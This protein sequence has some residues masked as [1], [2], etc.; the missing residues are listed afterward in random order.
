MLILVTMGIASASD[1]LTDV[2]ADGDIL[3][4]NSYYDDDFYITVPESYAQDKTDWNSNYIVYIS[5][6]SKENGTFDV[7]VD[8]VHKKA[9]I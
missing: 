8:D 5:S 7:S 3:M 1:N 6:Y 4:E 9:L 2:S